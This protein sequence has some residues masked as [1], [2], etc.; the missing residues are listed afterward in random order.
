[1]NSDVQK[2]FEISAEKLKK[3]NE[4]LQAKSAAFDLLVQQ[5]LGDGEDAA[6]ARQLSVVVAEQTDLIHSELACL[7]GEIRALQLALGMISLEDFL[8]FDIKEE[9]T[10]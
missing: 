5:G 8:K 2:A 9:L 10:P 6:K 7:S 4:Q 3:A 1:M